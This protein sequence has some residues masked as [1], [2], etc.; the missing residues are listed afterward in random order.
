MNRFT[1][2]CITLGLIVGG[3]SVQSQ[4]LKTPHKCSA[5]E[6]LEHN[7]LQSSEVR[8]QQVEFQQKLKSYL[9]KNTATRAKDGNKRIIPVVFHVIHECGPENIS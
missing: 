1:R 6:V 5:N 8:A 7:M 9:Q 4:S 2:F 3:A